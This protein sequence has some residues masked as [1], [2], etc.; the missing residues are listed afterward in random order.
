MCAA[1]SVLGVRPCDAA[2]ECAADALILPTFRL[3]RN[4]GYEGNEARDAERRPSG[5]LRA[6]SVGAFR[7]AA[8][9]R[10]MPNKGRE[11]WEGVE[12]AEGPGGL[13]T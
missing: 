11:D 9:Q 2:D 12:G 3:E 10:G 1:S 13:A 8:A 6:H 5:A 4:W 7:A